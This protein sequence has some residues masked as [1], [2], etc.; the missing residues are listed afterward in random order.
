[1][2][3]K[4]NWWLAAAVLTAFIPLLA[5]RFFTGARD[6]EAVHEATL[7]YIFLQAEANA[8]RRGKRNK[9]PQKTAP[10]DYTVFVS[11]DGHDPS[12]TFLQRFAVGTPTIGVPTV[13]PASRGVSNNVGDAWKTTF[14]EPQTGRKGPLFQLHRVRWNTFNGASVQIDMPG[15][16]TT[17]NLR[18]QGE[19]WTVTGRDMAWIN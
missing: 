13:L 15:S 4:R 12:L 7:R 18:R 16:G 3:R 14:T 1:M 17:Y 9:R 6:E 11:V 5:S 8:N 19:K 10:T 2:A